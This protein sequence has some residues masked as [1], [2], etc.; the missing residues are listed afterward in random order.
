MYYLIE[1]IIFLR[2]LKTEF[3]LTVYKYFL[4][5]V[6]HCKLVKEKEEEMPQKSCIKA[7]INI[8]VLVKKCDKKRREKIMRA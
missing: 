8:P 4:I 7:V 6:N 1:W 5:D 3:Q 2:L